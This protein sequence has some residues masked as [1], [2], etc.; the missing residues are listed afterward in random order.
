VP[1]ER[2][3]RETVRPQEVLR[4]D[5]IRFGGSFT[6]EL[7]WSA[8]NVEH[9]MRS[10]MKRSRGI[11]DVTNLLD[12]LAATEQAFLE[13][14]FFA[15]VVERGRVRVR[16]G[17]AVCK[18]AVEP[19]DFRGYGVF[20][21]M[22]HTAARLVRPT[23]LAERRAYLGL[24]PMVRLI[25]CRQVRKT[26]YGS[27]GSFGDGRIA[28]DGLAPIVLVDEAQPLET[29]C[30]RFDGATFWFDEIDPRQDPG[31]PLYLRAALAD[32]THPDQLE[33]KGL[34]AEQ[35][36][37]YELL[38]WE[39]TRPAD[40]GEDA[41]AT[42]SSESPH[43]APRRNAPHR[44]R[45]DRRRGDA[46]QPIEADPTRR[47][48]AESLSHA[49]AE[50]IDYLERGDVYRVRFLVGGRPHVSAIDKKDLTVQSAGICLSGEDRKF[51]L[52]SLVGVLRES[53][54]TGWYFDD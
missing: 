25:V 34:T 54:Q 15:P 7:K 42:G 43:N 35:R 39:L 2:P 12:R 48:L 8:A 9:S 52:A 50:L 29:V 20:R 6:V 10:L 44:R 18:L 53:G 22:S 17:G 38:H 26:W 31:T 41:D 28:L 51:D 14:E 49:G 36:A 3:A 33:R 16:I 24:F 5:R 19:D 27:A 46:L 13:R 37:A 23:T 45:T 47:R 1:V 32:R 21:P 11:R 30:A 4:A 40:G